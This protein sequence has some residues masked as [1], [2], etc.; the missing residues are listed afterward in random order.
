MRLYKIQLTFLSVCATTLMLLS[1]LPAAADYPYARETKN[2]TALD[3][4]VAKPDANYHWELARTEKKAGLTAY[5][6][7]LTSQQWRSSAE[8]D[9][10]V[11]KH[12][13]T[14]SVPDTV[15]HPTGLLFIEGGD[16]RAKASPPTTGDKLDRLA[17][18]TQTVTATLRMVPN[19]SLVFS[20]MKFWGRREDAL[21]AYT[22]DK[23]YRTG[24][25]EWPARLPMTKAA[26]RAMDAIQ[27]FC[28][29]EVAG[30]KTVND[31]VV[32]GGS[33]R[34]WATWTTAIVD[35]RVRAIVPCVIELLNLVP[36]FK[37]HYA[38]YGGWSPAIGDY[39][40]LHILDWLETPENEAM[41]RIIDPY[42]YL[43]RLADMPKFTINA[44]NDQF[45][46][47]DAPRFYWD[48]LQAPKWNRCIPNVGHG[49]DRTEVDKSLTAFYQSLLENAPIPTYT[50]SFEED[51]TI[52]VKLTPA[53]HG[54]IIPPS[55]VKLWQAHNPNAR[56]F[57]GETATYT[58]SPLT[59]TTPDT[60]RATIK[61]PEK[62]WS[63]FFVEL[64]FP[65]PNP[66]TPFTFTT[67]ARILPDTYPGVYVSNP[68]PPKGFLTKP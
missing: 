16:N 21:I 68:N 20:D 6:L 56:D 60:Y 51:G 58:A 28:K 46:V 59:P 43:D 24:D 54:E 26:V 66:D 1:A 61:A 18:K 53:A 32:I 9:R 35:T 40:A 33:K 8:V 36:S 30:Q 67:R 39:A 22:W 5:T 50:Y 31:F 38:V 41:M 13:L 65:G 55:A 34:G 10:P 23:F 12:W 45:F 4:Y 7:D 14:I 2:P 37:H 42:Y 19:Q 3:R 62:G 15:A 47:P 48:D 57:R 17:L 49:L 29:S 52:V 64:T 25:E 44:G 63:S 11:W 27:E